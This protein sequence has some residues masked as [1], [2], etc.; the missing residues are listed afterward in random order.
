MALAS[1]GAALPGA[2]IAQAPAE[3]ATE[4]AADFG[5]I[6]VTAR[7]RE[8][9]IQTVPIAI[10]A[11]SADDLADR[12]ISNLNDLTNATPGVA[13]T[14]ITGGGMQMIYIRGLAPA[15]TTNDLNTEANVGVFIDDIY[16]TSRNTLDMISVL[17]VGQIEIAKGPQSALFGRSTFAGAMSI[18]T[19]A[20]SRDFEGNIQ[21]TV[22]QDK[23]YRVRGSISAPLT[24]TLSLRVGGGY[25]TYDGFG[26]NSADTDDNLG[27]TEKYAVTAA[28]E[29]AP[30]PD[31]TAR[32]SGFLTSSKSELSAYSVLPLSAFNCGAVNAA[33]GLRTQYCGEIKSTKI[34]SITAD[35]PET[36]AESRQISLNMNWR[37]DGISVTSVTG[38]TEAENRSY[39]DYDGTANG[40]PFGVC[41]IGAGCFPAG[42][43]TRLTNVNLLSS[44]RERVR[45]F[46]QEIR[47]Q[48]DNS[49]PFQW[50]FGGS[51]FNSR[52]PLAALGIG[53]DSSGLAANERLVQV[54][55]VGTPAA[56]GFGAYDF[57]ANPFLSS[58]FM[59][60]QVYSSYT[61]ASSKT[62]SIFGS[63]GYSFGSFR[64]NAE[65]RYNI[66]RKL[67]QVLS[68]SN[69]LSAPGINVPIDG[70]QVPAAGAFP[71]TGPQFFRTF[72]S[73][74]PRFTVD[75]QVTPDIFLYATAAKGVRAGGFNTANPVSPTGILADET[76][77]E[78]ET[79]WTY[80][81]GVKTH[82]FDR[83]LLLNISAF[84]VDWTNA[85]VS[86]FTLNPTAVN[87]T[88]IVRNAGNIKSNGIEVQ[89]EL[90]LHDYFSV[91]GSMIYTDPKFQAGAYDASIVAQCVIGTGATATAA[92]GCPP[93]ILVTTPSG[94]RAVTSIEG[95][96]PTRSVKLQW[97][98]HATADVPLT[99]S[100]NI[101]GR[102]DV[103]HSGLTYGNLINTASFGERT[104]TSLRFALE[105][106]RYSL[107][108]WG[109]NIFNVLYT[110]NS[111][112]QPRAGYPFA[113][114]I[115]EIYLGE[116]RRIGVTASAKF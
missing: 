34:S 90:K 93:V 14:Q 85:Q 76:A 3:T 98:L 107:A 26:T 84:H 111:I 12:N 40:A 81:A 112:A 7:R 97:N 11:L 49:S 66:D 16:Q 82:L 30:T 31:F 77:Y 43:Y 1:I 36:K 65:G 50:I 105:N 62:M 108:V 57:T 24:D 58:D 95:K 19:R 21:A 67:A 54:N 28:L 33:T 46:S 99:D 106:D 80:E 72:E 79:N 13:I 92:P 10:T 18:S 75:Y 8:E 96:R 61:R 22:G 87:P 45:T 115:P 53:V 2:A 104:L 102:V 64:V 17:D 110:S 48:S 59:G 63:L 109:N 88:R 42:P 94:T 51:Y 103:S 101:T 68:V 32:L 20:P 6:F 83:R 37:R 41:T 55:P 74:A 29:F 52:I 73:F 71:V 5:E 39:N 114:S 100:W 44:G 25:L 113:F 47:F 69:P 15:N 27:G 70:T 23:D 91:G 60:T 4:A 9:S 35:Q 86:A 89:S 116:S 78:E 56:T 38:F